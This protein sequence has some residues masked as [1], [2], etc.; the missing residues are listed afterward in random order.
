MDCFLESK[1]KVSVAFSSMDKTVI[2][3][4][5]LTI[6]TVRFVHITS[7]ICSLLK[8]TGMSTSLDKV[9]RMIYQI[10]SAIWS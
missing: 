9:V 7:I 1:T 6:F 8:N 4:K 10:A 2:S 3:L 5:T